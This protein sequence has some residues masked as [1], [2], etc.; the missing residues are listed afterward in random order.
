MT[1]LKHL[2]LLNEKRFTMENLITIRLLIDGRRIY[3]VI[4]LGKRR[5][6]LADNVV[7]YR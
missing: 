6:G 5:W 2:R 3:I 4:T 1:T 7:R